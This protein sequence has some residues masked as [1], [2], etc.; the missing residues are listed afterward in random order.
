[1]T[2]CVGKV[3]FSGFLA[4][5]LVNNEMKTLCILSMLKCFPQ[6]DQR[7]FEISVANYEPFRVILISM[8]LPS[9]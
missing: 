4:A 8:R 9:H 2:A 5:F 6:D 7:H 1:M 3:H